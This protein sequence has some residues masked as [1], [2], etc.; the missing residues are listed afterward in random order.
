MT[1]VAG[2]EARTECAFTVVAGSAKFSLGHRLH[3]YVAGAELHF[4]QSIVAGIA[5]VLNPV[6]PMLEYG[7]RHGLLARLRRLAR[8][9]QIAWRA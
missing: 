1:P 5:P 2:F 6:I 8:Q 4:E 7:G 9:N 3:R